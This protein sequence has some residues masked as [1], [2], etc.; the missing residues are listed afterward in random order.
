MDKAAMM[1][2]EAM[3]KDAMMKKETMDK[4]AM[5]KKD[6]MMTSNY[7]VKS[8]DSLWTI[9]KEAYGSGAMYKKIKMANEGISD[10]L[11]VG[12]MIKLPK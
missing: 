8:G 2:K 11:E 9:A 7:M 5:M 1:K 6:H 3:D 4:D 12:Q 10:D